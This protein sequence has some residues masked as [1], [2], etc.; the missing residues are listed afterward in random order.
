MRGSV[1]NPL[2][3]AL[4][5][6]YNL[7]QKYGSFIGGSIKKAREPKTEEEKK[8]T[9]GVFSAKGGLSSLIRAL[10]EKICNENIL[11]GISDLRINPINEHFTVNFRDKEGKTIEIET[12]KVISTIGAY[13]L[14][15]VLPFIDQGLLLKLTSLHY[16]RV[17]EIV[18]G[19]NNWTGMDNIPD[20]IY[21]KDKNSKYLRINKAL[22]ALLG[23]ESPEEA[24]GKTDFDFFPKEQAEISFVGEQKIFREGLPLINHT[25]KFTPQSREAIRMSVTK[26]PVRD[27]KGEISGL[28]GVSRDITIM[29]EHSW[30]LNFWM[31]L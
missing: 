5:K 12:K 8:V 9:R 1:Y 11:S 29:G 6:L 19:F 24:I 26:I 20:L 4:P 27:G 22:A 10:E 28:I 15:K 2:L 25:E 13:C 16:A 7:E 23:L 18:L 14:D 30:P 21:F 17:I 31:S 3:H